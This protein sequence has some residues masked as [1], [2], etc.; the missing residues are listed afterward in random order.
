MT[1]TDRNKI[2]D[3]IYVLNDIFDYLK[4]GTMVFDRY[5]KEHESGVIS[6]QDIVAVQKM[7]VSQ[8]ILGL[9]KLV[10]FSKYYH[11]FVPDEIRPELKGTVSRL[12]SRDMT[13]FRNTVVAHIWD[14]ELKRTRTQNEVIEQLNRISANSP[15]AFLSWINNPIDNTYPKTVISIVYA[16]REHLRKQHGVSADE[17]FKR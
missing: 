12:K 6:Q 14:K 8:I 9:S 15:K 7:C 4:A 3:A 16:L 5:Q 11:Q 1:D 2:L 17:V 10:E 13:H